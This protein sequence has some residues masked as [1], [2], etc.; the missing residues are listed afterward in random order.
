MQSKVFTKSGLVLGQRPLGTVL[1]SLNEPS[2]LSQWF[3]HDDSTINMVLDI[4]I[5]IIIIFKLLL[6]LL[7]MKRICDQ[8]GLSVIQSL[9]LSVSRIAAK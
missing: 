6:L 5:I 4:I 3:C 9:V 7:L 8:C 1:H 2:E